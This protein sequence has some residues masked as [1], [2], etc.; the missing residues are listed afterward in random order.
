M[1]GG[2]TPHNLVILCLCY[3]NQ[4]CSEVPISSSNRDTARLGRGDHILLPSVIPAQ[5]QGHHN[6]TRST[7]TIGYPLRIQHRQ[8]RR[9]IT[10]GIPPFL[11]VASIDRTQQGI[12]GW[13]VQSPRC[14]QILSQKPRRKQKKRAIINEVRSVA[15]LLNFP[16]NVVL[17][18][19][20]NMFPSYRIHFLNVNDLPSMFRM[21]RAMFPRNRHQSVAGAHGGAAP[22]SVH[23]DKPSAV[24]ISQTTKKGKKPEKASLEDEN[25]LDETFDRL[26]DSIDHLTVMTERKERN[27]RFRPSRSGSC[28]YKR[29]PPFKPM[30][31][32]WHKNY[33]RNSNAPFRRSRSYPPER[34]QQHRSSAPYRGSNRYRN[35]R[36]SSGRRD[37]KFDKSPHGRKP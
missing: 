33:Y 25:L 31:S 32:R 1:W 36:Y 12:W 35:D 13:P 16:D 15:R 37:F 22:F 4:T 28:P 5:V 7:L 2:P 9:R 30:I 21:L 6:T 26:Q 10:P 11:A 29:H 14:P 34:Y 19:L 8:M 17:A 3:A 20:K 27:G 18:T 24:P 23:Q